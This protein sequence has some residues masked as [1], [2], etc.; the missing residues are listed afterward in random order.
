MKKIIFKYLSFFSF[1]LLSIQSTFARFWFDKINEWLIWDNNIASPEKGVIDM[2]S[3]F[4]TFLYLI[5]FIWVLWS[6][7]QI[8]TA[9]WDEEKVKSWKKR[10]LYTAVWLIVIFLAYQITIFVM[11]WLK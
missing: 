11:D 2:V 8:M 4:L 3:Y 6:G 9:A 5:A 10:I 1:F 7:F